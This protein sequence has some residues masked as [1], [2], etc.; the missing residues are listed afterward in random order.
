MIT[1]HDNDFNAWQGF[2]GATYE[3]VI[4]GF[5]P[6]GRIGRIEHVASYNHSIG[7]MKPNSINEPKQKVSLLGFT[8]VTMKNVAEMPVGCMKYFHYAK[9]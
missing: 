3:V 9:T 1:R 4:K 7:S 6:H 5:S 2:S 8:V